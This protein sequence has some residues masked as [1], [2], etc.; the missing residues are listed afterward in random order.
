MGRLSVGRTASVRDP[1]GFVL[2]DG[3]TVADTIQCVHCG[4]HWIVR[5]GSGRRRGFCMNCSGPCC[6]SRKCRVCIPFERKLELREK[7]LIRSED[8]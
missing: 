6:G 4:R 3:Q 1:A 5:P 2:G 7:G 8:L